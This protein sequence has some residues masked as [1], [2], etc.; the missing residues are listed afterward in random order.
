V[1][2]F[3]DM[4][5]VWLTPLFIGV[6]FWWKSR[7]PRISQS[8]PPIPT[9]I[10]EEITR[11]APAPVTAPIPEK[12]VESL[13]PASVSVSDRDRLVKALETLQRNQEIIDKMRGK[14]GN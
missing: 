10:I 6:L 3:I 4:I 2:W 7:G 11:P 9:P 1:N 12:K 8:A 13:E 5:P 14:N